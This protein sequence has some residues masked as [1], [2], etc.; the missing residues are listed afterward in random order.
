MKMT[1]TNEMFYRVNENGNAVVFHDSGEAV[2]KID[3]NVYPVDSDLS[4]R[5][6]HASGIVLTVADA[7]KIGIKAE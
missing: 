5:Y 7:E 3:A 2:T 4:A 6:E 1:T